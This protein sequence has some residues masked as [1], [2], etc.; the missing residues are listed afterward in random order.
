MLSYH[1]SNLTSDAQAPK[2]SIKLQLQQILSSIVNLY[3]SQCAFLDSCGNGDEVSCS[4]EAFI[5]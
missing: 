5:I 4:K 1:K 2:D 3:A